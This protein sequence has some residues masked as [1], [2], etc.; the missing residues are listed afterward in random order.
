MNGPGTNFIL[1]C[2]L[3]FIAFWITAAA[4]A[5]KT[6]ARMLHQWR[7]IGFIVFGTLIYVFRD[8]LAAH[9]GPL[10]WPHSVAS[11]LAGDVLALGGL[12]ILIWARILLGVNWSSEVEI[13]PG[14]RLIREGPYALVRHPIYTGVLMMILGLAMDVGHLTWL[15]LFLVCLLGLYLKSRQEEAL[16]TR[17]FP[18]EY[19]AY[20]AGTKSL[21][22]WLF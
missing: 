17:H 21:I 14:H 10:L 4:W 8:R 18:D 7:M 12:S 9:Q 15:L 6:R 20:R 2:F 16:L 3:A 5:A 19:P 13:Q 11:E 1:F 22:P